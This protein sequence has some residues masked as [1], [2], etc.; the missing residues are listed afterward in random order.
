MG[1][2]SVC[3]GIFGGVSVAE[4]VTFEQRLEAEKQWVTWLWGNSQ[5]RG[6]GEGSVW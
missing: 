4:K 2:R 6:Q 3:S 5:C 1:L